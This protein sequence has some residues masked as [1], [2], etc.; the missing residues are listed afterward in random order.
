MNTIRLCLLSAV[1]VL[2]S[3]AAPVVRDQ[4]DAWYEPEI[5][6]YE[7]ADRDA[8]PAPGG[9]LFVGSSSVRMWG[10]LAEDM[11]PAR[12]INRG[13]G[14]S[15]TP[16]VLAVMDRV[17][18]P[19]RP[20]VIVYYCGD[21]DLGTDNTDSWTAAHGFVEFVELVRER[22]PGTRVLYMSIKPSVARWSNWAA[23]E[24][25]NLVVAAYCA[26]TDEAEYVDLASCLLGADGR[27]D[28]GLFEADGL[29]LNAAGYRLW[30]EELR[31]R[32]LGAAGL[33][34]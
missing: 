33:G 18:F 27:P 7:D 15:K 32:V 5:R 21:N 9:V 29:H 4:P 20:S 1:L 11:A 10:T 14:G 22:L 26:S 28:P 6:A 24:R 31:P 16:E 2:V 13:F 25:A 30:A 8:M 19:Y 23:M 17:V 34:G 12:V 3:C